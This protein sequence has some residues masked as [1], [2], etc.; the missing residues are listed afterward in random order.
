MVLCLLC[1]HEP[2]EP[3]GPFINI[4]YW[5]IKGS[6]KDADHGIIRRKY[7]KR[8]EERTELERIICISGVRRSGKSTLVY[9]YIRELLEKGVEPERIVLVK[10]DLCLKDL[11]ELRDIVSVYKELTGKDPQNDRTYL[12]F[13]EVHYMEDWQVQ[14]KEFIDMKYESHFFVLGSPVTMMFKDASESLAGRISFINVDPLSF[15]EYL[16][17]SGFDLPD[18][19][20]LEGMY[21]ALIDKKDLILHHLGNYIPKNFI[22]GNRYDPGRACGSGGCERGIVDPPGC[23]DNIDCPGDPVNDSD[24]RFKEKKVRSRG[25]DGRLE[26]SFTNQLEP[27]SQGNLLRS[28]REGPVPG[29]IYPDPRR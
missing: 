21:K 16:I 23:P 15:K 25:M 17:F 22:D 9:Q 13:D 29:R 1:L 20:S 8:I 3:H 24:L 28:L 27:K 7:I 18:E 6:V 11:D 4:N 26:I 14:V 5:W 19:V 12:F 10:V 2:G